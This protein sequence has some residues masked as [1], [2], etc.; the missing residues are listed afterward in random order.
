MAEIKYLSIIIPFYNEEDNIYLLFEELIPVLRSLNKSF[1]VLCIDDGSED[2][3]LLRLKEQKEKYP[4]LKLIPHKSNFGQS[5]AYAT[6]FLNSAGEIIVTMDGDLQY[7]AEDILL[8]LDK[9]DKGVDAVCG[10]RKD[11]KDSLI[12]KIPSKIGNLLRNVIL[13][14]HI[15]DMGC[16]LRT[17]KKEA[18]KEIP[19][20]RGMHRFLP[21]ILR[22]QGYNVIECEVRHRSR[23]YGRSKYGIWN[24][25]FVYLLDCLGMWWWKKRCIPRPN[26]RIKDE[27]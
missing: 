25:L 20:F 18:L 26:Y 12:K 15:T 13:Q 6:G 16:T 9:L 2:N 24:R 23:L 19:M 3:T 10:I 7:Y 8:L 5:A 17:I 14:D 11:R 27:L 1:E 22:F 21:S 4:E